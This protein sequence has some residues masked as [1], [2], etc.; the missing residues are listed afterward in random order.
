MVKAISD[1]NFESEVI[2]ASKKMP[3]VVD[4]WASW[5]GPSQ[6]MAPVFDSVAEE[7][8][9]KAIFVKLNTEE[10]EEKSREYEVTSIPNVKMFKDGKVVDEFMGVLPEAQIKEWVDK[11]L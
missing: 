2:E 9:G 4:F 7:Y 8:E 5:C 1:D 6:M 3:V 10:N 11:N